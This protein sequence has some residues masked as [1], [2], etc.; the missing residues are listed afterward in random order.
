VQWEL[1][2]EGEW[3]EVESLQVEVESLQVEVESF[4][5]EDMLDLVRKSWIWAVEVQQMFALSLREKRYPKIGFTR[6]KGVA[7]TAK[8]KTC[9]IS[10]K[11]VALTALSEM[12]HTPAGGA[13]PTATFSCA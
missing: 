9:N 11:A 12:L 8:F 3:L 7:I 4:Q 5:E 6:A 13:K 10:E 1:V 2:E